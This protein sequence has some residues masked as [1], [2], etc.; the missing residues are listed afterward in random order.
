[1]PGVGLTLGEMLM[2]VSLTG[3]L[4]NQLFQYAAALRLSESSLFLASSFGQPRNSANGRPEIAEFNL[5]KGAVIDP[6]RQASVLVRKTVGYVLRSSIYP[7]KLEKIKYVQKIKLKLASMVLSIHY[8]SPKK[9]VTIENYNKTSGK[10]DT[11]VNF[12]IGYFQDRS[13]A[14]MEHV[15]RA[16]MEIS[17]R[18]NHPELDRLQK[19]SKQNRVLV[20]HVRRGDY[21]NENFG[22]LT[23]GYYQKAINRA[24]ESRVYDSIWLYSDEGKSA[25]DVIPK[26]YLDMTKVI[27][28]LDF[29]TCLTFE[30]MRYGHGYVIANSTF[31]WWAAFLSRTNNAEVFAPKPWF[32]NRKSS[33]ELIPENWEEIDR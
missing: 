28:N 30:S 16:M 10:R 14:S 19:E 25:L 23:S 26:K 9:V 20:V 22:I 29:S 12:L 5:P 7:T 8:L 18:I 15:K 13:F 3:G 2:I 6:E 32:E 1:M 17:P 4:G 11:D 31:S 33:G 21:K 27:E 24:F